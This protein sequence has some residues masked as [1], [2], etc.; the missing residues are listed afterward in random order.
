M[1]II[2]LF[3]SFAAGLLH[4]LHADFSGFLIHGTESRLRRLR[5]QQ[6]TDWVHNWWVV[7]DR[8][9][10]HI[11]IQIW[12]YIY[13]CASVYTYISFIRR[14]GE[15]SSL[16]LWTLS[17][18]HQIISL[19]SLLSYAFCQQNDFILPVRSSK[20]ILHCYFTVISVLRRCY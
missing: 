6:R 14:L 18:C 19:K 10:I 1:V 15:S 17:L 12:M 3:C 20:Q 13:I 4:D 11:Y 7:Q 8:E 5:W 2:N 16:R 9:L